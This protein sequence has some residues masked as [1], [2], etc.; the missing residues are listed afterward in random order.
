MTSA[1]SGKSL[2]NLPPETRAALPPPAPGLC[3]LSPAPC[4]NVWGSLEDL[5]ASGDGEGQSRPLWLT[6]TLKRFFSLWP[7]GQV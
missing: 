4:A 6:F 7:P 3:P 5:V 2:C 1:L